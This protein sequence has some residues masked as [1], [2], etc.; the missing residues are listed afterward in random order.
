[1]YTCPATWPKVSRRCLPGGMI[2]K[3][4]IS[5]WLR[6]LTRKLVHRFKHSG[7]FRKPSIIDRYK[8]KVKLQYIHV[9]FT[10][11]NE[12]NCHFHSAGDRYRYCQ[13]RLTCFCG[14]TPS[15]EISESK[16]CFSSD[17]S[18]C[19]SQAAWLFILRHSLLPGIVRFMRCPK[20]AEQ[21]WPQYCQWCHILR[22]MKW[23]TSINDMVFNNMSYM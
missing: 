8:N 20:L 10:S 14:T 21:I 12:W 2:L 4:K 18:R 17:L 15:L 7:G 3:I 11:M 23:K 6:A 5:H 22:S 16:Q 1:M 9:V 19:L 13:M